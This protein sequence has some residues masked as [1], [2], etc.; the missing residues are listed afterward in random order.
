MAADPAPE[1]LPFRILADSPSVVVRNLFTLTSAEMSWFE[2][3]P[4]STFE[5]SIGLKLS[6]KLVS[7]FK[8]VYT[9]T[10]ILS[11]VESFASDSLPFVLEPRSRDL[12]AFSES[13]VLAIIL[14]LIGFIFTILRIT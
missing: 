4:I 13:S 6:W 10:I 9:L 3:K 1:M 5:T 14:F 11:A 7:E 12:F 2:L 8:I